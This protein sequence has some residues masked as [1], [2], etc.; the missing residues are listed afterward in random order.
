RLQAEAKPER[1]LPAVF[2]GREHE[3][4]RLHRAYQELA[5]GR[6]RTFLIH[7]E[8]GI[9]KTT[10]VQRFSE[11]IAADPAPAMVLRGRCFERDSVPYKALDE[12]MEALSERLL[13]LDE[14]RRRTVLPSSLAAAARIFPVLSRVE[15]ARSDGPADSNDIIDPLELR[16]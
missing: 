15:L 14:D 16:R 13:E 11:Q 9:G 8:S 10:L 4:G 1:V 12:V 7:G 3:L 5:A 6:T 2:V